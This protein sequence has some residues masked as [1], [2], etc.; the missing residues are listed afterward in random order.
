MV[1]IFVGNLSF[2]ADEHD[3]E[4]LFSD[5]GDVDRASL[6]R[7]PRSRHSRGFGFVEMPDAVEAERAIAA[8]DGRDVLGRP[9]TV[10]ESQAPEEGARRNKAKRR[11]RR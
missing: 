2:D 4:M 8:L 11:R 6:V 9:L 10:N 3:L 1:K 5:Y 7:H